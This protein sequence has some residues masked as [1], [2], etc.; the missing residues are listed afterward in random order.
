MTEM[1]PR[2]MTATDKPWSRARA[3]R[4]AEDDPPANTGLLP[5]EQFSDD[6]EPEDPDFTESR[7]GS[8]SVIQDVIAGTCAGWKQQPNAEEFYNAMR[9]TEPTDRQL[10]IAGVLI[11]EGTCHEVL[12]AYLQGA[13]TWRQLA[14]MMHRRGLYRGELAR[15][16]NA[17]AK[18]Q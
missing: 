12:L 17:R 18:A 5:A 16:V 11:A 6:Y 7:G 13:F 4:R 14:E 9:A 2:G 1:D 10:A 3:Q 15:F 8:S